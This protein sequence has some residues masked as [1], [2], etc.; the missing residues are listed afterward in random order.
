MKHTVQAANTKLTAKNL[1]QLA[2]AIVTQFVTVTSKF[3]NKITLML[4][5]KVTTT[6]EDAVRANLPNA[7]R[8]VDDIKAQTGKDVTVT[9]DGKW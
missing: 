7:Q 8:I 2:V 6:I 3:F 9:T 5:L 1:K 4:K